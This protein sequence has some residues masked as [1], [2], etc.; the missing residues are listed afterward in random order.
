VYGCLSKEEEQEQ[1]ERVKEERRVATTDGET[2]GVGELGGGREGGR[3]G[4]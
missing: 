1:Y 2:E 3:D 4:A